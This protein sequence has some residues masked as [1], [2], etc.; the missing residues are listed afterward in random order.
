[1]SR[2]PSPVALVILAMLL[3]G[4]GSSR[5]P[6]AAPPP[7]P[8]VKREPYIIEPPSVPF[9]PLDICVVENG[10]LRVVT[11]RYN[12][13]TADSTYEGRLFREAFPATDR[14]AAG[15]PWYIHSELISVGEH[16]YVKYGTRRILAVGEVARVGDYR[17][18]PVFAELDAPATAEVVYVPVRPG[19]EFQ[20]YQLDLRTNSVRGG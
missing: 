16:R 8:P 20:P 18:V 6:A 4:C 9:W 12:A 11:V 3:E 13:S 2:F 10:E 15:A 19:C 1:M 5:A 17:G 14:Y 7:P